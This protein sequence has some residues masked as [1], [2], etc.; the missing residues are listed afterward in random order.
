MRVG[1]ETLATVATVL[2][3]FSFICTY[4][5]FTRLCITSILSTIYITVIFHNIVNTDE[6]CVVVKGA[7]AFEL[8]TTIMKLYLSI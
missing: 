1:E 3:Q 4:F 7:E 5:F 2:N 8:T 6:E